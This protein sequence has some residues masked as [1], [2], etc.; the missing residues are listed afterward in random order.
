VRRALYDHRAARATEPG[1]M[2]IGTIGG[3]P[4]AMAIAWA[5]HG[6]IAA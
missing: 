1:V 2:G 4:S 6:V 5:E 3:D